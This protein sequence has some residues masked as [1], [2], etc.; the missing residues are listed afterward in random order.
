M[1]NGWMQQ[2]VKAQFI[3][4]IIQHSSL[5]PICRVMTTRDRKFQLQFSL[6][7]MQ[8]SWSK[9]RYVVVGVF[10][11]FLSIY[12]WLSNYWLSVLCVAVK[13][14]KI[15][16]GFSS[17][18]LAYNL[19][20]SLCDTRQRSYPFRAAG[21]GCSLN[22]FWGGCSVSFNIYLGIDLA[23]HLLCVFCFSNYKKPRVEVKR[24]LAFKF[25]VQS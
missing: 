9:V 17:P 23:A 25:W 5:A 12:V 19:M 20:K 8:C 4:L 15:N 7:I 2:A 11:N 14:L 10:V 16:L 18:T 22:Q 6:E 1:K 24:A 3:S 21:S 13:T